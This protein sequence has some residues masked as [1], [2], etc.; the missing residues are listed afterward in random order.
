MIIFNISVSKKKM[1][2]DHN[3]DP[4]V[5]YHPTSING[6]NTGVNW[7]NFLSLWLIIGDKP[8][9]SASILNIICIVLPPVVKQV[10]LHNLYSAAIC[11]QTGL[12]IKKENTNSMTLAVL[13][14]TW[15][16]LTYSTLWYKTTFWGKCQFMFDHS[17]MP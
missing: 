8:T 6:I 17:S 16:T 1:T 14:C 9:F 4:L 3:P 13:G 5:G 15:K 2:P 12:F 7:M 11:C 10:S